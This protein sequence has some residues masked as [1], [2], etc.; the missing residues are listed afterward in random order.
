MKREE[1]IGEKSIRSRADRP[2]KEE[3]VRYKNHST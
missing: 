1:K 3:N 2:E